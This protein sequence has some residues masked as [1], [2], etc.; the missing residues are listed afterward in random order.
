MFKDVSIKG[1]LYS[2]EFR[3]I[4]KTNGSV[5]SLKEK[6]LRMENLTPK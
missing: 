3:Q 1:E 5:C 2:S 4:F 6:K